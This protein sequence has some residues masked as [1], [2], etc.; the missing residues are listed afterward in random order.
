MA[1]INHRRTRY[2]YNAL[3]K[4]HRITQEVFDYCAEMNFIDAALAKKWRLVGYEQLCCNACALPGAA[5]VAALR[6][7]K[8]AHRHTA[9]RKLTGLAIG[10]DNSNSSSSSKNQTHDRDRE[11]KPGTTCVC[12]VPASQR[13][14]KSFLACAVCGCHGCCSSDTTTHERHGVFDDLSTTTRTRHNVNIHTS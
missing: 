13:R 9:E 5:S 7:A 10:S 8:Y 6:N 14:S 2:V 1:Q 3:Y 11:M 12:R 4:H